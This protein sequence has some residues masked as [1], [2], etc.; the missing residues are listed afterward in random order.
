M[1][2]APVEGP[3]RVVDGGCGTGLCG[4]GIRDLWKALREAWGGGAA[5]RPR[6]EAGQEGG[7]GAGGVGLELVG[8]DLS[9][10]ML[11]QVRAGPRQGRRV[12]QNSYTRAQ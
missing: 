9:P 1:L 12:S 7:E 4:P 6:D 5:G 8:V 3:W 11:L 2:P 10:K